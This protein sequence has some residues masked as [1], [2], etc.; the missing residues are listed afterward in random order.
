M[1]VAGNVGAGWVEQ[2]AN[3]NAAAKTTGQS[4]GERSNRTRKDRVD[5]W[6]NMMTNPQ[7]SRGGSRP[8]IGRERAAGPGL[9]FV[10]G[11]IGRANQTVQILCVDR[12]D[13]RAD[14]DAHTQL[15]AVW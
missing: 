5:K 11:G 9:G 7:S 1:A 13:G 15:G 8:L 3:T 6:G 14:G 10:H 4:K 2:A 12:A